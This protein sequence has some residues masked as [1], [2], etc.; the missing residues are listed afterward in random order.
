MV[1]PLAPGSCGHSFQ[2][3]AGQPLKVR[4]KDPY[5]EWHVSEESS[6]YLFFPDFLFWKVVPT[7]NHGVPPAFFPRVR[8]R[9]RE[10]EQVL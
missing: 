5:N 4:N 8:V 10:R 9:E 1:C 7:T 3:L 2:R 6:G